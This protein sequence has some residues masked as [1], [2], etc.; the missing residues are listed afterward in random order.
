MTETTCSILGWDPRQRSESASVGELNANCEAKVMNEGGTAEVVRGQAGELWVRAPNITKGY[1]RNPKATAETL[2][3]DGWLKTGDICYVDA[4]NRFTIVDRK[5]ELI[6]VKGHQVAPA[7]LEAVLLE[8]PMVTDAGV[9]GV[10]LKSEELPRAYVVVKE[11]CLVT[12]REIVEFM[13]SRVAQYKRL[14]GGIIFVD[15]IPKNPVHPHQLYYMSSLP[16]HL[17]HFMPFS[18]TP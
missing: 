12:D 10:T 4:D 1:W 13:Q 14:T 3:P 18:Y 17:S 2:T 6:K 8:H 9:I 11:G 5:K 16:P 15:A 7:E